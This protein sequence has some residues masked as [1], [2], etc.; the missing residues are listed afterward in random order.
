MRA[1]HHGEAL[2]VSFEEMQDGELQWWTNFL[3][4]P[5]ATPRLFGLYG[6]RYLPFFFREFDDL[7]AVADF[8]SGPVSAAFIGQRMTS[9]AC[10]D[11]L[12]QSYQDAGLIWQPQ[13]VAVYPQLPRAAFDTAL[14]LNTL[15]HTPEPTPIVAAAADCIKRTGRVL[16]WNHIGHGPDKL[17]TRLTHDHIRRMI[18]AANLTIQRE[19][20]RQDY[21]P[22]CYMALATFG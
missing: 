6:Y 10:I 21:G 5:D 8:G 9:L 7:G 16:I 1:R 22:P 19:Q 20:I 12:L 13:R 18:S 2:P 15:D 11:P 17:H 14:I 4:H 3:K